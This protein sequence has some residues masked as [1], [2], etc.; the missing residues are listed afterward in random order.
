MTLHLINRRPVVDGHQME[1]VYFRE[2]A[3]DPETGQ[4]YEVARH[5]QSYR[6][7]PNGAW[8]DNPALLEAVMH[9][10]FERDGLAGIVW[11]IVLSILPPFEEDG[12]VPVLVQRLDV[13][14]A[15]VV[16]IGSGGL[17]GEQIE[18]YGAQVAAALIDALPEEVATGRV[19]VVWEAPQ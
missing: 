2:T 15:L 10:L 11:P 12:S 18:A 13:G 17:T 1:V 8:I 3:V 14:D 16:G 5:P 7:L 9:P 6:L 4:E 19:A